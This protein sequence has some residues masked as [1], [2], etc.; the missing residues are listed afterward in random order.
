MVRYAWATSVLVI[1]FFTLQPTPSLALSIQDLQVVKISPAD[2]CAIVKTSE[3]DLRLIKVG[4]SLDQNSRVVEITDGRIVIQCKTPK[5]FETVIIRVEDGRQKIERIRRIGD[6]RPP[7][8][9]VQE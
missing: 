2:G 8:L 9:A 5:G 6:L 3:N 1:A 4:S 7:P